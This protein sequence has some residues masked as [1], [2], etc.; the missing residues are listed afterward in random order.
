MRCA[1]RIY[2]S[3][4]ALSLVSACTPPGIDPD[5]VTT[6]QGSGEST[7]TNTSEPA[8]ETETE[9]TEASSATDFVPDTMPTLPVSCDPLNQ[10]CPEG[11]KCVPYAS[12]GGNWD[13]SKCV[14]IMGDQMT[15]EPCTYA[16]LVEA[17]DDCDG[18]GMCWNLMEVD[19]GYVG[20]CRPFCMGTWD[21]PTC[22]EGDKCLISGDGTIVLCVDLCDPLLQD[23][24]EGL[25]CYFNGNDFECAPETQDIEPGQPC[26]FLNDCATPQMCVDQ[27]YI[28]G[29][30]GAS[31]C[32][33]YCDL[34][35]GPDQCDAVPGTSC[36]PFWEPGQELPGYEELGICIME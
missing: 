35:G 33:P 11:E 7:G 14:P 31:C 20:T 32:T 19:D 26:G 30:E 4:L 10:D 18:S 5:G 24:N 17:T 21:A 23:C 3:F 8:T 12:T 15:D 2:L 13:S 36:T 25:G 22:P 9:T 29:C 28:P 1:H 27:S 6:T 16:G 34:G